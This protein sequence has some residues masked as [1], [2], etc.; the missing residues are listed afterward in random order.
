[1]DTDSLAASLQLITEQRNKEAP[2][3]LGPVPHSEGT[4]KYD[5]DF[6][7]GLSPEEKDC[8]ENLLQ[9]IDSLD[10]DLLDDEEEEAKEEEDEVSHQE[11][12]EPLGAED[13]CKDSVD[14][15][16]LQ[17]T[18]VEAASA[19]PSSPRPA[20]SKIK[21][22]KSFSEESA[23]ITLRR[24]RPNPSPPRGPRRLAESH[25]AYFRKFDTIMRSGVNVQEL[26]SRFL[27][28]R[29]ISTA[30]RGPTEGAVGTD[31]QPLPLPG[32]QRSPR[33]EALQKLGLFQR[34]SSVPNMKS[35]LV[36][37]VGQHA[38]DSQAESLNH[39]GMAGS[40]STME[41]PVKYCTHPNL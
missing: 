9:T 5:E 2:P 37:M 39:T 24:S 1:M 7:S 3:E 26:R 40:I 18:S 6:F 12:A 27:H 25:P 31:K 38:Q 35:P 16:V 4:S 34:I 32:G 41:K 19:K 17:S 21:M 11:L 28:H 10:E 29:D 15:R 33:D 8:L 36:P 30:V 22:T 23:D 14:S 13:Q 20:L